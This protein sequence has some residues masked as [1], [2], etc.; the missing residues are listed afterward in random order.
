V[1]TTPDPYLCPICTEFAGK[2]I[3]HVVPSMV[4]WHLAAYADD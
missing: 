2:P 3:H 1:Q 4:T